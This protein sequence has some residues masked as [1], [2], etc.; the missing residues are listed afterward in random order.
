LRGPLAAG[1]LLALL[2]PPGPLAAEPV[3][4]DEQ[5][6][7]GFAAGLGRLV[8]AAT[9][10]ADEAADG[11]PVHGP[12]ATDAA[13]RQLQDG[14]GCTA[15]VP[16]T[17]TLCSLGPDRSLY[18]TVTPAIVVVGSVFKCDRC[19]DWH[20]GQTA[21]GWILSADGLVVTNHHVLDRPGGN[22][23]GVMT[24]DGQVYAV[25]GVVAADPVG[26]AAVLQIDA[27]GRRLPTLAVGPPAACG[28]PVTI[29]SHPKG[30]FYCLTTGVV[31]RY[32]RQRQPASPA[33]GP[34]AV[35]MSVTADYAVGSSGG[36]VLNAA[37]EV[38]GMVSR[39]VS[40]QPPPPAVAHPAGSASPGQAGQPAVA[41]S[42]TSAAPQPPAGNAPQGPKPA[43]KHR[44][45]SVHVHEQM[46]FKDC[47]SVETM[48]A[49]MAH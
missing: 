32:H 2:V 33:P 30:R 27:R 5:L 25:T 31:S 20:L 23:Y 28:D 46:V 10:A 45:P 26:D 37:G 29:I 49:L 15:P 24:S 3:I 18:E 19:K 35:W 13:R 11:P 48:R 6:A 39:T 42:G 47:V 16:A 9:R 40:V 17:E 14:R 34:R 8:D 4:D 43:E 1:L 44:P 36:P 41:Q 12:L 21:S 7:R 38:V 22:H